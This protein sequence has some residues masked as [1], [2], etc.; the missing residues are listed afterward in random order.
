MTFMFLCA[1][2][3]FQLFDT[4]IIADNAKMSPFDCR[5]SLNRYPFLSNLHSTPARHVSDRH[6]SSREKW[7]SAVLA[8]NCRNTRGSEAH[9]SRARLPSLEDRRSAEPCDASSRPASL[10]AEETYDGR[11]SAGSGSWDRSSAAPYGARIRQ[12]RA[13]A[14]PTFQFKIA[15]FF[16]SFTG[17]R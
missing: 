16:S 17:W 10:L 7:R 9:C 8:A 1:T 12:V 15:G 2:A 5:R 4:F 3:R 13:G 6:R 14:I 11:C